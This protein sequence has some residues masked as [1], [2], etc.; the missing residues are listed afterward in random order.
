MVMKNACSCF[1]RQEGEIEIFRDIKATIEMTKDPTFHNKTKHI[2]ICNHFIHDHTIRGDI[3]LK[4]CDTRDQT[5]DVFTK[6]LSQV[7]H[8]QFRQKHVVCN[9]ESRRVLNIDSTPHASTKYS[10]THLLYKPC[11]YLASYNT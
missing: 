1:Y 7:K 9:F 8:D 2:D 10:V 4:I 3:E 11:E 6:A 5:A